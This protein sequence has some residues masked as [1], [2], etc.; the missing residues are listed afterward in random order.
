MWPVEYFRAARC[1]TSSE[2]SASPAAAVCAERVEQLHP[3]V[4]VKAQGAVDELGVDSRA[5]VH[6]ETSGM[7][8]NSHSLNDC[9]MRKFAVTGDVSEADAVAIR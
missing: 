5:A 6:N 7:F 8:R 1:V 3:A 9:G 4:S 2:S